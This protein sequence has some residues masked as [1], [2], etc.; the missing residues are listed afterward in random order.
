[1]MQYHYWAFAPK[2]E[3]P[4]TYIRAVKRRFMLAFE[5]WT[6]RVVFFYFPYGLFWFMT[7]FYFDQFWSFFY[8][9]IDS[10]FDDNYHVFCKNDNDLSLNDDNNTKRWITYTACE[11]AVS[12]HKLQSQREYTF[13]EFLRVEHEL[14]KFLS[15]RKRNTKKQRVQTSTGR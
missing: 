2:S 1:M 8:V 4:Y 7:S 5:I 3:T 12:E 15:K 13:H 10:N 11:N 6:V 14:A 9:R